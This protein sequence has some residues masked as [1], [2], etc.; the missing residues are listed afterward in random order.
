M[1]A[2]SRNRAAALILEQMRRLGVRD[3]RLD[4]ADR[5][6]DVAVDD[7]EVLQAVEIRVEEEAAEAERVPGRAADFDCAA[8]RR[9]TVRRRR[10]CRA[11]AS[12]R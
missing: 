2:T 7:E 8:T 11:P 4:L 1:A 6:V 5:V 10:A 9:R 12:R 3:A